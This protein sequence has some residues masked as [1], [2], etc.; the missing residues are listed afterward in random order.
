MKTTIINKN[1]LGVLVNTENI[2][3]VINVIL[4]VVD[5][6]LK[7]LCKI[8]DKYS[9]HSNDKDI[10]KTKFEEV[11]RDLLAFLKEQKGFTIDQFMFKVGEKV[12]L[13]YDFEILMISFEKFVTFCKEK[14]QIN[15]KAHRCINAKFQL[16]G[17]AA[18]LERA[19]GRPL[20]EITNR[21]M[22]CFEITPFLHAQK[23]KGTKCFYK[24][25]YIKLI[26]RCRDFRN[27]TV[28]A[29]RI[30]ELSFT[31]NKT[32]KK[33]VKNKECSICQ[34]NFLTGQELCRLPC[35]H[36]FH[37]QCIQK[38]FI[39]QN[40]INNTDE[41]QNDQMDVDAPNPR[42][43]S[44][45]DEH[46]SDSSPSDSGRGVDTLDRSAMADNSDD[47]LYDERGRAYLDD[48]EYW[49]DRSMYMD[50]YGFNSHGYSDFSD[51][52]RRHDEPGVSSSDDYNSSFSSNSDDF[53]SEF[54]Y[55][56]ESDFEDFGDMDIEEDVPTT[57]KFQCPNCRCNC[58]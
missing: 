17:Y 12:V 28:S 25:L 18:L 33:I 4:S 38:W 24:E 21:D 52:S 56:D 53:N 31:Y 2:K 54:S 50:D 13:K 23:W 27:S 16:S 15:R 32:Y 3:Y 58:C 36:I 20:A 41:E 39:P 43:S 49:D 29:E 44:S 34:E 40:I 9:R 10:N 8:C 19:F 1:E 35:N 57:P 14:K 46:Y 26:R 30:E 51:D 5:K 7:F 47:G 6:F 48:I 45:S 22:S 11:R 42:R 37:R 55:S